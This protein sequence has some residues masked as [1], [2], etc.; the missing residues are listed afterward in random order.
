MNET[1]TCDVA[2]IGAGTAGLEARR[3]AE[4][5]GKRAVMI[6]RGPGG[7]TCASVGCMPSKLLL[8]AGRAA[9]RARRAGLFG[10]HTDAVAVDGAAVMR[11]LRAER[12][13]FAAGARGGWSETPDDLRI[14][15]SARFAGPTTL[16]IEDGPVVEAGAVV[17]AVGSR[18]VVPPVL[19]GLGDRVHTYETIFEIADLPGRLL[20]L[21]AGALG[22]ELAQAFSW[23]GVAVTVVDAGDVVSKLADPEAAEVA[24]TALA[25]S[26]DLH[27]GAELES[28]DLADGAI[29]LRWTGGGGEFD[30]VLAASGVRPEL[31][32]LELQA[33]GL[34]LDDHGTPS[35]DALT[36]RCG[37]S[38]VFIAGDASP[39]RPVLHE[40]R[41]EGEAAGRTVSG[42]CADSRPPFLSM[43]FTDPGIALVGCDF[44]DLP[45]G[46]R[47]G[48]ADFADNGRVRIDEGPDA[49]GVA[50]VYADADGRL[51]GGAIVGPEAEHVAHLLAFAVGRGLTA[52]E[53]LDLP[54]Y[55]PT[56][57]E[58]LRGAVREL[59]A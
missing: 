31:E 21:G 26:F 35:F 24:R 33:A 9:D 28:A 10:V 49:S 54:L 6:E 38:A 44:D 58:V 34:E 5:A 20:V 25:E 51:I 47:I 50:R 27:L 59:L 17:I 36:R 12:D 22:L 14:E 15:G 41:L 43:T 29:V 18:P 7:T 8:A 4:A 56:V 52:R 45:D 19:D 16:R 37:T 3:V 2:I 57:A 39:D 40:A 53:F 13:R 23:L 32:P 1:V 30:L 42:G 48:R 46:H 55:H 11:R